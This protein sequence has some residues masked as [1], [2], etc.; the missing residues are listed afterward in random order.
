MRVLVVDDESSAVELLAQILEPI[1]FTVLRAGGGAEAIALAGA[2]RP[3]LVLLD[4]MMPEVNGF[5]VVEALKSNAETR[6]I[7]ILVITA[8][9]LTEEE[10]AALNGDVAAVL[11]KGGFAGVDLLAWLEQLLGPQGAEAGGTL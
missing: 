11:Q 8:K 1:G 2:Q 9:D 3:D 10:K 5:D 7:P 4:L 6:N